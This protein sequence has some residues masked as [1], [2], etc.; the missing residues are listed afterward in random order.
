[1]PRRAAVYIYTLVLI[2][3]PVLY[4]FGQDLDASQWPLL[5]SMVAANVAFNLFRV[6]TPTGQS[7][8]LSSAVKMMAI[9]LGGPAPATWIAFVGQ[10]VSSMILGT[11]YY[12]TV[13]NTAQLTLTIGAAGLAFQLVGGH[14]PISG[15][16]LLPSVAAALVYFVVNSFFMAGLF[17]CLQG[18]PLLRTWIT[19]AKNEAESYVLVLILG[20]VATFLIVDGG[21]GWSALLGLLLVVLQR[22]VRN[23]YGAL[24][25]SSESTHSRA[26]QDS[27]LRAMVAA[28]DARDIYTSGHSGRVARYVDLITAEMNLTEAQRDELKY[29]SLLHDVG[30]LGIPDSVLRKDGPLTPTERALMMEHPNRGINIL[31]QMPNVPTTVLQA[32]KHHHEWYNGGGYPDGIKEQK[33]PLGA[34]IIAVADALD[35]MTSARPYRVGMPW[36]EAINR[37]RQGRGTQFDPDVV[38]ALLK[39]VEANP[40]LEDEV[41]RQTDFSRSDLERRLEQERAGARTEAG[42]GTGRILPVHSKEVKIL[43]TLALERRS[44]LDL[45]Q[46]LHR[47]LEVLYDAVGAHVYCI[48]LLDETTGDLVVRS[49]AGTNADLIGLRW[50]ART[51][52]WQELLGSRQPSVVPDTEAA[53]VVTRIEPSARSM[54]TV[55]LVTDNQVIGALR[56]ESHQIQALGEDEVYLLT[57]VARQLADAIEVAR[58]HEMMTYAA[59]HDGLTG[60]LNRA[61]FYQQLIGELEQARATGYALSVAVLDINGFK[62]INDTYGHLAGDRIMQMFGKRLRGRLRQ[63]DIVARYGGDE[64]AVIMP[65]SRKEDAARR[66]KQIVESADELIAVGDSRIKLPTAAWGVASFPEE[67]GTAE[68][69]VSA[70]DQFMYERKRNVGMGAEAIGL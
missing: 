13:F 11:D 31:G 39:V 61:T 20:L 42:A 32:V 26:V 38:N 9:L 18:K 67:G 53:G 43:Y 64:F 35:A 3:V 50:P 23:Y 16:G 45:A 10:L 21:L 6:E 58:A 59:T 49:V 33:I 8:T 2:A 29:A 25:S 60:V 46:T 7:F 30:K 62:A 54:V 36:G 56:V 47:M 52:P 65:H 51:G 63:S 69:L 19:M 28:L 55:P 37:L 70:A 17:F 34:R 66:I 12:R 4:Y 15:A 24:R 57:A 68:E 48:L 44:L 1:M 5:L 41:P 22:V 14:P 40:H 27:L